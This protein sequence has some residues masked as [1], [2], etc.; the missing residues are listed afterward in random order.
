MAALLP[1]FS[2]L[3]HSA[4]SSKSSL[5]VKGNDIKFTAEH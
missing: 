3:L 5:D 1:I 4:F 2:L